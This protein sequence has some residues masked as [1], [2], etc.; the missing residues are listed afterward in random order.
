MNVNIALAVLV[1]WPFVGGLL[2]YAAG[3]KNERFRDYL[4][5]FVAVSEF[6]LAL[7]LLSGPCAGSLWVPESF[8]ASGICGL[9]LPFYAGRVSGGLCNSGGFAWMMATVLSREYFSHHGKQEPLLSVPAFDAGG[10]HRGIPFG[11]FVYDFYFLEIM[12][13]T[14]VW[15]AQEEN[16][17]ALR[18]AETYL[19]VAVIGGLVMLMDCFFCT[20]RWG[21]LRFRNC[22][23][24]PPRVQINGCFMWRAYVAGRI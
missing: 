14:F 22:F 24:R 18:A 16:G 4:A 5:D 21:R 17:P 10:D 2:C 19:A 20:M 23:R 6:V 8:D 3:T 1:F 7:F 9:G 11:R 15:V 13:F 12:S